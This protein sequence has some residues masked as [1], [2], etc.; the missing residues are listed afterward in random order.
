LGAGPLAHSVLAH[1]EP[2]LQDGADRSW[3]AHAGWEGGHQ[4]PAPAV[5]QHRHAPGG[6]EHLQLALVSTLVCLSVAA[7]LRRVLSA[8]VASWQAPLLPQWWRPELP[9]AP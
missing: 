5:P 2:I 4:Q 6:L 3:V 7:V 1:G 9:G 8:A